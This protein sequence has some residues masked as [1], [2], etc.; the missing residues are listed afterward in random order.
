MKASVLWADGSI[1]EWNADWLADMV[2]CAVDELWEW[3]VRLEK[4]S[5]PPSPF[6]TLEGDN[7]IKGAS[8][9]KLAHVK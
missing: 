2:V 4:L 3:R 1:D 5:A 7:L 6:Q 9:P 8:D